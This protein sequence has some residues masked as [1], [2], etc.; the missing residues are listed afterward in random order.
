MT[1]NPRLFLI[2]FLFPTIYAL[3]GLLF[4]HSVSFLLMYNEFIIV[5]NIRQV[6]LLDLATDFGVKTIR[7]VDAELPAA[8]EEQNWY[9]EPSVRSNPTPILK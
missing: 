4:L 5:E 8:R 7:K 1:L 3:Q 9:S 2:C 6:C